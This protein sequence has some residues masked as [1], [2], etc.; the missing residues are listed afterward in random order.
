MSLSLGSKLYSVISVLMISE[1]ADPY[2]VAK[3]TDLSV[4]VIER[5]KVEACNDN[6]I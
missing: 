5:L 3:V 1:N 4:E 6:L 2:F